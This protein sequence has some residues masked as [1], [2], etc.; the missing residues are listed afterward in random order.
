[1]NKQIIMSTVDIEE[2]T[3]AVA[4]EVVKMLRKEDLITPADEPLVKTKDL[5]KE[6]KVTPQTIIAWEKAGKIPFYRLANKVF[7][8]RSEVVEAMKKITVKRF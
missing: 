2:L 6:L 5:A 7:F 3:R 8:K 1:M 4:E